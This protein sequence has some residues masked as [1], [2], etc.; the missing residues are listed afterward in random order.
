[1]GKK[2]ILVVEDSLVDV[3]SLLKVLEDQYAVDVVQSGE[4][5][6]AV[7][8]SL[9]PDLIL[10]DVMLPG[11]SGLEVCR[12][13]TH[14][15]RYADIPVIIVTGRTRQS[16]LYDGFEAGAADYIKKPFAEIELRTRIR[17]VLRLKHYVGMLK[18]SNAEKERLINELK[19]VS[20]RIKALS[21]LLPICSHCRRIRDDQGYWE[22]LDEYM[23]KHADI[24]FSH[25]LCPDCI[26]ELYPTLKVKERK[27]PSS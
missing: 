23:T 7:I 17:A 12:K 25:G 3:R 24:Q 16:D 21:E 9:A 15:K 1:M 2:K 6:L 18:H 10:L 27:P 14:T 26:K 5:A 20:G 8:D 4:D 22:Q 19:E 13:I 11:I